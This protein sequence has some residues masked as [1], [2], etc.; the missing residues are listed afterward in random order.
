MRITGNLVKAGV[1]IFSHDCQSVEIFSKVNKP[2]R[3]MV[4]HRR[5]PPKSS[6]S[7]FVVEKKFFD[8]GIEDFMTRNGAAVA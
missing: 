3:R 8:S 6:E 1:P 7:V 4:W 2:N 5:L